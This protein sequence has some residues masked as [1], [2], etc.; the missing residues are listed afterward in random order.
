MTGSSRSGEN[1]YQF[2][3]LR[4]GHSAS[5]FPPS[6]GG[7]TAQAACE[8]GDPFFSSLSWASALSYSQKHAKIFTDIFLALCL[9]PQIRVSSEQFSPKAIN[10]SNRGFQSKE[11]STRT[12]IATISE[13][14][15]C[16]EQKPLAIERRTS[17][18]Q[19]SY[20]IGVETGSASLPATSHQRCTAQKS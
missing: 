1:V 3:S 12:S 13:A 15:S 7:S 16:L 10:G 20:R 18:I 2:Q 9:N 5:Y 6:N 8:I 14:S 17:R 19:A 11:D 4:D